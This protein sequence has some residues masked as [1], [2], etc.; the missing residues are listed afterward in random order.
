MQRTNNQ[1]EMFRMNFLKYLVSSLSHLLVFLLTASSVYFLISNAPRERGS[2]VFLLL[3]ITSGLISS[4]AT[5]AA[6][7][8]YRGR[9]SLMNLLQCA[10]LAALLGVPCAIA[11]F[12]LFFA[13]PNWGLVAFIVLVPVLGMGPLLKVFF[14]HSLK[15]S[16]T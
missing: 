12:F 5:A 11:D 8:I 15:D 3:A 1:T 6:L 14:R 10:M 4:I 2:D 7:L 9:T 16:A 13:F